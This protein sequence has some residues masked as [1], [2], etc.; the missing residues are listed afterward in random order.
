MANTLKFNQQGKVWV[1]E[2]VVNADY[3]LHIE[4]VSPGKFNIYQR[5]T[6]SGQ[7]ALCVIPRFLYSTGQ[8][9]DW[10]FGHGYYPMHIRIESETEVTSATLSEVAAQ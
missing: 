10:T 7:Y 9:I 2:T 4:R 6:D 5:S 3:A 8:V 1:C